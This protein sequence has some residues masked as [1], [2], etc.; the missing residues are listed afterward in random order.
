M[1]LLVFRD[2]VIKCP[3]RQ[4]EKHTLDSMTRL[5]QFSRDHDLIDTSLIK[6]SVKM[7]S[8]LPAG[9]SIIQTNQYTPR[10]HYTKNCLILNSL[11]QRENIMPKKPANR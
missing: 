3:E 11:R 2:V 7:L 8:T 5:I 9:D 1:G 4:V 6:D 10:A